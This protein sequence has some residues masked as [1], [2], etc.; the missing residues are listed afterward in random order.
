MHSLSCRYCKDD[1]CISG[2]A[3]TQFSTSLKVMPNACSFQ[4]I[5]FGS[6]AAAKQQLDLILTAGSILTPVTGENSL[7]F[8]C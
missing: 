4:Y 6:L 5:L 8:R 3:N 1:L 7:T 2:N